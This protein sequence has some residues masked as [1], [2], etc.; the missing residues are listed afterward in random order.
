MKL[1]NGYKLIYEVIENGVREFRASKTGA[2]TADDFVITSNTIGANKLIYQYEGMFYG[3]GENFVPTYNEDGTPADEAL[4]SEEAYAEVFVAKT[5]EVE[6]EEPK[7]EEPATPAA[8][9]HDFVEGTCTKCGEA[10]PDYV[11]AE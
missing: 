6:T 8:C 9:E 1:E 3:T 5:E 7:T 4:I 10:D 2:P 11:P